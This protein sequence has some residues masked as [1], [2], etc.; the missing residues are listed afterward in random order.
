MTVTRRWGVLAA[1]STPLL[2]GGTPSQKGVQMGEG[3]IFALGGFLGG[4]GIFFFNFFKFLLFCVFCNIVY[5]I[6]SIDVIAVSG[7]VFRA[8]SCRPSCV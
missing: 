6:Y 5:S 1:L 4:G 2:G 8:G 7:G 3:G